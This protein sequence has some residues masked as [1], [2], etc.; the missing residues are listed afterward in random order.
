MYGEPEDQSW[1]DGSEPPGAVAPPPSMKGMPAGWYSDPLG[2]TMRWWDA[3]RWTD[4]TNPPGGPPLIAVTLPSGAAHPGT[5]RTRPWAY[6]CLVLL[7]VVAVMAAGSA[8]LDAKVKDAS[9]PTIEPSAPPADVL[10]P[11]PGPA[12]SAPMTAPAQPTSGSGSRPRQVWV[13][14]GWYGET[15]TVEQDGSRAP[16]TKGVPTAVSIIDRAKAEGSCLVVTQQLEFWY[17]VLDDPNFGD[18][19][20]AYA[21]YAL[22]AA[23]DLGCPTQ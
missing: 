5:S 3:E 6:V 21:Q 18:Y 14:E 2:S 16:F 1:S 22:E 15:I 4:A 8:F 17:G 11:G 20:S 23:V 10:G 9:R 13:H 12:T 19:K 7:A